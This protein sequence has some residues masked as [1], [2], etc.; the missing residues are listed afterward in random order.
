MER[1]SSE[2]Y[3]RVLAVHFL[4]CFW[5][6]WA[7]FESLAGSTGLIPYEVQLKAIERE[8]DIFPR[9][10]RFPSLLWW[11]SSNALFVFGSCVGLVALFSRGSLFNQVTCGFMWISWMSLSVCRGLQLWFPWDCLLSEMLFLGILGSPSSI[12]RLLLFRVLF[13]FG[14]HKFLGAG[15]EDILYLKSMSCWQP[16]S[17][18][19]GIWASRELPDWFHALGIIFTFLAEIIAPFFIFNSK[20]RTLA[21]VVIIALMLGIQILGNFGCFNTLTILLV[22]RACHNQGTEKKSHIFTRNFRRLYILSAIIFL[23]PSQWNSPSCFYEGAFPVFGSYFQVLSSFRILH[24]YGVFPPKALPMIKPIG[25]FEVLCAESRDNSS[26]IP[27]DYYYQDSRSTSSVSAPL[28]VAPLRFPRFDYIVGFYSASHVFSL[29]SGLGPLWG[30]GY[31]LIEGT[32][33]K[34]FTKDLSPWF[35]TESVCQNVKSVRFLVV[36]LAPDRKAGWLEVS[37]HLHKEWSIDFIKPKFDDSYVKYLPP[38]MFALRKSAKTLE[39]SENA[40]CLDLWGFAHN[41][42]DT[43]IF[44]SNFE[45]LKRVGIE[46][47]KLVKIHHLNCPTSHPFNLDFSR[48]WAGYLSCLTAFHLLPPNLHPG[49]CYEILSLNHAS[50]EFKHTRIDLPTFV[51]DWAVQPQYLEL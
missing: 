38:S 10:L 41:T 9:M 24:S 14:K 23:I 35:A 25:R 40:D 3:H 51:T 22:C 45:I 11:M 28:T 13:G 18:S 29:V 33:E 17:T 16:L 4:V 42:V 19:F 8:F 6:A 27:L 47:E 44:D 48:E 39:L 1:I 26:W 49:L 2:V 5:N 7:D 46:Y 12:V 50:S 36:G 32:V 37:T 15:F 31:E 43:K 30:S 21:G 20:F 34:I